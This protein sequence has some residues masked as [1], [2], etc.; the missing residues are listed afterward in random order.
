MKFYKCYKCG[1]EWFSHNS[2]STCK[3]CSFSCVPFTEQN[4]DV[5]VRLDIASAISALDTL[6]AVALRS[7]RAD[8]LCRAIDAIEDA[9]GSSAPATAR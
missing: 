6:K 8:S 3:R 1:H 2:V 5:A 4:V 7:K 9:I